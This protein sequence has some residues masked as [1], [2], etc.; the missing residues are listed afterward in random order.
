MDF[1]RESGNKTVMHQLIRD[2]READ[3]DPL[4]LFE[5]PLVADNFGPFEQF[6]SSIGINNEWNLEP[7]SCPGNHPITIN[8]STWTTY[9]D[10]RQAQ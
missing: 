4:N 7:P 9:H 5:R 1:G 10:V 8:R 2:Y 3:L 6:N